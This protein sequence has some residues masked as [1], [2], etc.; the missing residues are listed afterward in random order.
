MVQGQ[1][2]IEDYDTGNT[3]HK[4]DLKKIKLAHRVLFE[5]TYKK[6]EVKKG[7]KRRKQRR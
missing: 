1:I 5:Y 6:G 4:W 2:T 3:K 7:R